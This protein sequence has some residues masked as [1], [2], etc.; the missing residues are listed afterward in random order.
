MPKKSKNKPNNFLYVLE[1]NNV[2]PLKEQVPPTKYESTMNK[3]W[4]VT[5]INEQ[6]DPAAP[7]DPA[8]VDPAAAPVDPAAAPVD[9]TALPAAEPET[10]EK[11]YTWLAYI[12]YKCLMIDPSEV[13]SMPEF[14]KMVEEF[15]DIADKSD[16]ESPGDALNLFEFLHDIVESRDVVEQ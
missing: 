8:A 2:H 12:A 14:E 13:S 15:G 11:P 7:V 6:T 16:I 4:N 9:T 5:F 3:L 1:N 10:D